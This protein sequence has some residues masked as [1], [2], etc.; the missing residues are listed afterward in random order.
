M[1]FAILI[2]QSTLLLPKCRRATDKGGSIVLVASLVL[3]NAIIS[4]AGTVCA[5][6]FKHYVKVV[7]TDN[8]DV[9]TI[10]EVTILCMVMIYVTT[11]FPFPH[12]LGVIARKF[13]SR[14]WSSA[15]DSF[16]MFESR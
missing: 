6:N 5:E 15:V 13:S 7:N 14:S 12:T 8:E 2:L 1:R 10:H 16:R 3:I 11:T 9:Q 4:L